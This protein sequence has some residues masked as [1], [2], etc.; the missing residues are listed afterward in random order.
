MSMAD[1]VIHVHQELDAPARTNLERKLMEC[2]GV[3]C[4]EFN[5]HEHPHALVVKYDPDE[6]E[7]MEILSVV[8]NVDPAASRI[9]L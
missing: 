6:V 4:A 8:R 2:M 5:H 3:D 1:M 9:G 7:A